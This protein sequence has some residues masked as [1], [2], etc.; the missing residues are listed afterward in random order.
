MRTTVDIDD[1]ILI[2]AKALARRRKKT[3]GAV[4]SE[5]ARRGLN[6]APDTAGN[7]EGESFYGFQP[8]PKRGKPVTNELINR[9]RDDGP[10]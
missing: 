7:E 5:L 3:T 8:W 10:Y 2:A 1:D 9:L 6:S 4:L